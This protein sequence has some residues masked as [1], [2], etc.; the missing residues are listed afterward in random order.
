VPR[1]GGWRAWGAV[2]ADFE[3]A[4]AAPADAAIATAE[5]AS[6]LRRGADYV[7]FRLPVRVQALAV[8]GRPDPLRAMLDTRPELAARF[9]AVI[10]FPGYTLAQLTAIL[11]ALAA[12]AGL[13]FTPAATSKAATVLADAENGHTT[14][15]AR[16]AVQLLTR[17]TINQAGRVTT[18][19]QPLDPA[20]LGIVCADD[21]PG[22]LLPR[23]QPVYEHPGQY[24]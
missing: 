5:V 4:L 6:E 22:H 10:A 9:F 7:W 1:R 3:R 15:N 13:T 11:Q 16:L 17:A 21:I 8:P 19:P 24:L 20:A 18:A 12:E 2:R 23:D 14:G